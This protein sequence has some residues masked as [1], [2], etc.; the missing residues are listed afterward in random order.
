MIQYVPFKIW[1]VI[2]IEMEKIYKIYREPQK[3]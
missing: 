2:I 1:M 3:K